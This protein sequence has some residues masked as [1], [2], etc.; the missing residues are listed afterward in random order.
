MKIEIIAAPKEIADLVLAL[1]DRQKVENVYP[2]YDSGKIDSE[3]IK[4]CCMDSL[5]CFGMNERSDANGIDENGM[6]SSDYK[7]SY[8]KLC[9]RNSGDID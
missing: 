5:S 3:S 2:F 4:K 9:Y 6:G 8:T 1:Q 7:C